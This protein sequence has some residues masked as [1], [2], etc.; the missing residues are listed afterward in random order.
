VG[1]ESFNSLQSVVSLVAG[2]ASIAG[3]LYSAVRYVNPV[4]ANG[5]LL[6]VVRTANGE[7]AVPGSTIEVLTP[8][9]A[10]VMTLTASD[11]GYGNQPLAEGAYHVRAT[12][13]RFQPQTRDVLVQRDATAVVRFQLTALEDAH[14]TAG[15]RRTDGGGTHPV[16]RSVGAAERFLRHLGL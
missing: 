9:D 8:A 15:R 3:A 7:H 6:A 13:P 1:K 2:I 11:D 16:S 10:V 12:A 5:Q 14:P 4:P